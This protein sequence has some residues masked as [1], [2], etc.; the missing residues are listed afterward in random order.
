MTTG[1]DQW[2]VQEVMLQQVADALGPEL[3]REMAFVGGC[4]TGLL[5]TDAFTREAVRFTDDVDVIVHVLRAGNWYALQEE[6]SS[7]GFRV[8]P[9]DEVVCTMRLRDK[10]GQDLLVDF[11]PNDEKILGFTNRWYAAALECAGDHA[12]PSGTVI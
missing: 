11:M 8:S 2:R 5:V 10:S 9:E 12:L 7:K 4:T 3:L 6:L 1:R